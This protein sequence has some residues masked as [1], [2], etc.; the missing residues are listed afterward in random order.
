MALNRWTG[1]KGPLPPLTSDRYRLL[2]AVHWSASHSAAKPSPGPATGGG[3]SLVRC[4]EA[5]PDGHGSPWE[6]ALASTGTASTRHAAVHQRIVSFWSHPSVSGNSGN[7]CR[8]RP[9]VTRPLTPPKPPRPPQT[10]F[11]NTES[12]LACGLVD[13]IGFSCVT[14]Q[15]NVSP[16]WSPIEAL[17][18][19]SVSALTSRM[20]AIRRWVPDA[21]WSISTLE[22]PTLWTPRSCGPIDKNT[23]LLNIRSG[24]LD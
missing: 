23:T 20:R 6:A 24:C 5:P 9:A 3:H 13:G 16:P 18:A 7:S 11:T 17:P 10:S 14:L 19:A 4:S 12:G 21:A 2:V 1:V 15:L 22:P 8:G